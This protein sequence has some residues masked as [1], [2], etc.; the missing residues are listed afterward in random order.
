MHQSTRQSGVTALLKH[1]A[2][3]AHKEPV[4]ALPLVLYYQRAGSA[5]VVSFD[6]ASLTLSS[7]TQ[8]ALPEYDYPT[9]LLDTQPALKA[10]L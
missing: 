9:Q 1:Y 4:V 10:L 7:H 2:Q 5:L 3:A 6:T 8:Q